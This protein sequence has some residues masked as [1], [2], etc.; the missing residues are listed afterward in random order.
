MARIAVIGAG[1]GAMAASARLAT[2]GHRVTVYERAE[3]YGGGVRLYERDGFRFDTGPGILHLPAVYRDLFVKTGREKL[4]DVVELVRLDPAIRHVFPDGTG[5][6]LPSGSRAGVVAALD[7]ALGTGAGERWTDMLARARTVWDTTRRPLLEEPLTADRIPA[8]SAALARDPYPAV[9]ARGLL[10]RRAPTLAE[11]AWDELRDPRAV[12]MLTGCAL[13]YG[14]DPEAA[15]AGAAVLAYLEHTFGSWYVRGGMRALADALYARCTERRV[16]FRFGCEVL[17]LVES[18]GRAAGVRTAAE[19]EVAADAVV[20][21]AAGLPDDPAGQTADVPVA[22]VPA[23]SRLT[24]LLALRGERPAGTAHRT[25]VHRDGVHR[26]GVHG[27]GMHRTAAGRGDRAGRGGVAARPVT[28]LRPDDPSLVPDGGHEA[29]VLSAAVAPGE[30]QGGDEEARRAQEARLADELTA[31]ADGAGLGLGPRV[32]WREV[33][34]PRDIE[35][36][37]GAPGGL[38]P[39]PALAGPRGD[40]PGRGR[41]AVD[42]RPPNR[43]ATKGL[44]RAGGWAHPGGGAAHA[45]MSGALVAGLIVEGDDWRG[46]Y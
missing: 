9:R 26:D 27:D 7:S 39:A 19:G 4:E 13:D 32:L 31:A 17:G 36:E 29:V 43:T 42:V 30:L 28:V 24:V 11:A 6:S 44:Y 10:R 41:G 33:R 5:V 45:G 12:S 37:T 46:S 3:T 15:P 38:V 8:L 18:D 21:G 14:L 16:D 34:T 25:V 23:M 22:D 35:R 20:L 40:A 2:A 1:L